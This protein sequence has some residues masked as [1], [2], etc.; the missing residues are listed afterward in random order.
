MRFSKLMNLKYTQKIL[1]KIQQNT[2]MYHR[3]QTS[4]LALL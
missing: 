4:T 1:Q 3:N 2:Y